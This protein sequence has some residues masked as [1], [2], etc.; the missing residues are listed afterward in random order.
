M[1]VFAN[2]VY[3]I[4]CIL[5]LYLLAFTFH[6]R[7]TPV[8]SILFPLEQLDGIESFLMISLEPQVYSLS[9]LDC[10]CPL[11]SVI[12]PF[13]FPTHPP[14]PFES[15]ASKGF[16]DIPGPRV[17]CLPRTLTAPHCPR[18]SSLLH[19]SDHALSRSCGSSTFGK[20]DPEKQGLP[21]LFPIPHSFLL[22]F[23]IPVPFGDS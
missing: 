4:Y 12:F 18:S 3:G 22:I 16:L 5:W 14:S 23:M 6:L 13:D 19:S 2:E 1:N 11:L 8:V 20:V 10:H 9:N 7:N 17:S 21:P 15:P